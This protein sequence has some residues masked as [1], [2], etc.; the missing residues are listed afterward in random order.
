MEALEGG[1]D[2]DAIELESGIIL[3]M[4]GCV[5]ESRRELFGE[6]VF[7]INETFNTVQFLR[8]VVEEDS[9]VQEA[10]EEWARCMEEGGYRFANPEEAIEWALVIR[11][12]ALAPSPEEIALAVADA[13]CR[14]AS[15]IVEEAK[16]AYARLNDEKLRE[17]EQ[18]LAS[19]AEMETFVLE[20]AG[21]VL[22]VTLTRK[23]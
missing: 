4:G 5:G 13:D 1:G 10:E 11:G 7:E 22:G 20:R 17:N 18:I 23:P 16:K 3:N 2:A 15:G 21:E 14:V 8:I 9:S 12:T 6:R 19:W